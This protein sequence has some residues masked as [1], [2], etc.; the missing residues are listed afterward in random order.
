MSYLCSFAAKKVR[1]RMINE[2]IVEEWSGLS[3]PL[4][5]I[6]RPPETPVRCFLSFFGQ[7][8]GGKTWPGLW[9]SGHLE[10]ILEN[11]WKMALFHRSIMKSSSTI[12]HFP[13]LCQHDQIFQEPK[14][15]PKLLAALPLP[16][17]KSARQALLRREISWAQW[18]NR[19]NR[20]WCWTI[21]FIHI[22]PIN[23]KWAIVTY[24]NN[25]P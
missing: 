21:R 10:N 8:F 23:S 3:N 15:L 16:R 12:G 24:C 2:T 20:A 5:L 19:I 13:W 18:D 11:G 22:Y 1:R 14:R 9:W 6:F 25:N 4:S 17:L 7:E